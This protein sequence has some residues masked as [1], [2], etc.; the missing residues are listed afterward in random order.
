MKKTGIV[1]DSH[2]GITPEEAKQ[3]G[4]KVLPM[5]FY[6]E[7]NC[8]Y[9][10]TTI[11]RAEFFE[12]LLSGAEITTSQPSPDSVM[13]MWDE[14]LQEYEQI[15]YMPIS[16]G[17]SG[18]CAVAT[19]FAQ[20]EK[21]EG[22]VFVVDHGRVSTPLRRTIMDAMEMVSEGYSAEQI[23]RAIETDRDN[24][25]IYI[26]VEN[27]D[28]LRRGGRISAAT[29][30]VA[31]VLN[32]KPVLQLTTGLLDTYKKCHGFRNARKSMIEAMRRALDT[33]FKEWYDRGEVY[34]MAASSADPEVT[35]G[36]VKEIEDAF[37]GMKVLCDDLTLGLSA[38]VGHGG[39][40]IGCSCRPRRPE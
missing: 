19:A 36:W 6:I 23:K 4:I 12:K 26:G 14:A 33:R 20:E 21:Y 7:G 16:S 8:Y 17:L 2:S 3:W 27:L 40:G 29:A 31:T 15:L 11:S 22:K 9:E 38:H 18:S 39:L 5:P 34:L 24:M 35:A 13:R 28:C 37:P 10:N 32:I 25:I 1:T 30:A